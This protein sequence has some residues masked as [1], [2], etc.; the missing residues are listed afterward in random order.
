MKVTKKIN[1]FEFICDECSTKYS[2]ESYDNTCE[3]EC[4]ECGVWNYTERKKRTVK[5]TKKKENR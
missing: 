4:P 1:Q 5:K 3:S 2:D